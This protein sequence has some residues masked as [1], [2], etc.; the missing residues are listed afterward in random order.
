MQLKSVYLSNL[1]V[2]FPTS[3]SRSFNHIRTLI[4]SI[5]Q[6][7]KT[8]SF[9]LG[10]ATDNVIL[11]S[12]NAL[13]YRYNLSS[14]DVLRTINRIQNVLPKDNFFCIV[15]SVFQKFDG[16]PRNVGYM[17]TKEDVKISPK[18][19]CSDYD[20]YTLETNFK[21]YKNGIFEYERHIKKWTAE[22]S[23]FSKETQTEFP[24]IKTPK[25][26][27]L[28]LR[29]CYDVMAEPI[30]L[31]KDTITLVPAYNI[32]SADLI[33]LSKNRKAVIVN[34]GGDDE[35]LALKNKCSNVEHLNTF[36]HHEFYQS[37]SQNLIG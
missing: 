23:Y 29:I 30:Y 10:Y 25:N 24:Y 5:I 35:F 17:F 31:N 3:Y 22:G 12:E 2:N 9:K 4:D 37:R 18:R 13:K 34:D 15:F 26:T 16:K 33:G 36:N 11:F 28:E 14:S 7:E 27:Y 8:I 19:L 21:K 20:K 32:D 1:K 6:N